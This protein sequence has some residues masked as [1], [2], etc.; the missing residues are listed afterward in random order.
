MYMY[1]CV[2]VCMLEIVRQNNL[3]MTDFLH[4][5]L[6]TGNGGHTNEH[7]LVQTII[8]RNNAYNIIYI[9]IY[10]V[11]LYVNNANMEKNRIVFCLFTYLF[12]GH[13]TSVSD[14]IE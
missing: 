1:V 12:L 8:L 4:A 5:S 14:D 9:Y 7:C 11:K 13:S 2:Y 6:M 10:T 3:W